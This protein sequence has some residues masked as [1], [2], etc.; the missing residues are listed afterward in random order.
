MKPIFVPR[1]IDNNNTNAQNLNAKQLLRSFKH[2]QWKAIYYNSPDLQITEQSNVQL[3][4]LSQGR[5]WTLSLIKH[6]LAHYSAVFYPGKERHDIIG[7]KLRRLLKRQGPVISTIEGIMG[8]QER[9]LALTTSFNHPVHCNN[10]ERSRQRNFDALYQYS[11]HVIAI[12]P[13][14][15]KIAKIIYQKPVT[16]LPLGIDKAFYF[17]RTHQNRNTVMCVG[18]LNQNKNPQLFLRAAEEFP[19]IKFIWYGDGPLLKSLKQTSVDKKL[20]NIEFF[21]KIS[22]SQLVDCYR[23][24]S[25]F[26][27]PSFS[28]GA[29]KVLQEAAAASLPLVSF[30]YYEPPAVR[31]NENGYIVWSDQEFFSSIDNLLCNNSQYENMCKASYE[32]AQDWEWSKIA[33]QWLNTL[34]SIIESY[35]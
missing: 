2:N 19:K 4:Q 28:E 29:P 22:P 33:P 6:Y 35:Y 21:G 11:D 23:Q 27:L 17:K 32:L 12:S 26:V 7:L 9:E 25:I 14:L 15:E 16:Y 20:S 13:F 1:F 24:A 30:G 34:E 3:S 5:F 31:H 10:V 18:S 8:G